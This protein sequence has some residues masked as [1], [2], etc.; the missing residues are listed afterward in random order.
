[1]KRKEEEDEDEEKE[2]ESEMTDLVRVMEVFCRRHGGQHH[3]P[4]LDLA[5]SLIS[6]LAR[7]QEKKAGNPCPPQI[8]TGDN[9]KRHYHY[10]AAEL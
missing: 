1:M 9:T 10:H 3:F 7:L 5:L 8:H 6:L 2:E 4:Y